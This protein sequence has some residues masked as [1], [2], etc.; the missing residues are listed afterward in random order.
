MITFKD[1]STLS[2]F[3]NDNLL[4]ASINVKYLRKFDHFVSEIVKR[5]IDSYIKLKKATIASF[6]NFEIL[7][8]YLTPHVIV[9]L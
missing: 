9:N 8:K 3:I 2:A 1:R 4:N 6:I 7:F 5:R